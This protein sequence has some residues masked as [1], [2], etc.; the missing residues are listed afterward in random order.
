MTLQFCFSKCDNNLYIYNYRFTLYKPYQL[1]RVAHVLMLLIYVIH[2]AR[3]ETSRNVTQLK[4][5]LRYVTYNLDDNNTV[6]VEL[7]D[8]V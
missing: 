5:T 2:Q 7:S 6:I 1:T 8:I 4:T 3:I